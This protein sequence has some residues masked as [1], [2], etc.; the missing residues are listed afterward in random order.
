[1]VR[2]DG[3]ATGVE[4]NGRS[5]YRPALAV[6]SGGPHSSLDEDAVEGECVCDA[7]RGVKRPAS[8]R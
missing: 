8:M 4:Q 3:S 7:R 2:C 5:D 6:S 1:M